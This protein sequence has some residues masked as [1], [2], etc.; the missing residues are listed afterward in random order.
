MFNRKIMHGE[1]Q[2]IFY[3]LYRVQNVLFKWAILWKQ[4]V[5]FLNIILLYYYIIIIII[6]GFNR[7]PYNRVVYFIIHIFVRNLKLLFGKKCP[8]I[9]FDE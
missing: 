5:F 1:E 6:S 4:F 3:A 7:R 9:P 8:Y 2:Y